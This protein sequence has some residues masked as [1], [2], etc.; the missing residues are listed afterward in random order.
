M[1]K[2]VSAGDNS[3]SGPSGKR[4]VERGAK[5]GT[6]PVDGNKIK[7][8]RLKKGLSQETL[9]QLIGIDARR[10]Q[11]YENGETRNA[12][13]KLAERIAE[14]LGLTTIILIFPDGQPLIQAPQKA[15]EPGRER[16]AFQFTF[17]SKDI[18]PEKQLTFA[19]DFAAALCIR[20]VLDDPHRLVSCQM[21]KVRIVLDVSSADADRIM[22]A[23]RAGELAH[24]GVEKVALPDRQRI[25][26][27]S[28][29][30]L[31][32]LGLGLGLIA[33][34]PPIRLP[35]SAIGLVVSILGLVFSFKRKRWWIMSIIA[36]ILNA[37][38]LSFSLYGM[39]TEVDQQQDG[40]RLTDA[41]A[42]AGVNNED[43][44]K[45]DDAAQ[46]AG[47][48]KKEEP[49]APDDKKDDPVAKALE[50][51]KEADLKYNDKAVEIKKEAIEALVK[52]G[53][54]SKITPSNFKTEANPV[55]KN[56]T[57]LTADVHCGTKSGYM[58]KSGGYCIFASYVAGSGIALMERKGRLVVFIPY[59][60]NG[61]GTPSV[62]PSKDNGEGFEY[63]TP[64]DT[65]TTGYFLV[66]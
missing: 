13:V 35:V 24:L 8:A 21:C 63:H 34:F 61:F 30:L 31:S 23:F 22:Q 11:R 17:D 4:P 32:L 64:E 20:G 27:R 51:V 9:A 33:L 59:D 36:T 53:D 52:W 48:Q 47:G 41:T 37:A 54:A 65:L 5:R 29:F 49:E 25:G 38:V 16:G 45:P 56:A 10:L 6:V 39:T 3:S 26:R 43:T 40:A 14:V 66:K 60:E 18:P 57:G 19:A 15:S 44:K 28:F 46:P 50:K 62:V 7:E 58:G 55:R 2:I 12:E 42:N 1:E